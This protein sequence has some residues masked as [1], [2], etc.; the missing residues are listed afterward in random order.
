MWWEVILILWFLLR[1]WPLYYCVRYI[2]KTWIRKGMNSDLSISKVGCFSER[3]TTKKVPMIND[4]ESG[5]AFL[6][7]KFTRSSQEISIVSPTNV[8]WE[9]LTKNKDCNNDLYY[10]CKN[11]SQGRNRKSSTHCCGI[12]KIGLTKYPS[13]S[14]S[15]HSLYGEEEKAHIERA[16]SLDCR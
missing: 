2:K 15:S 3:A 7:I 12:R 6:Q 13:T 14:F 8:K 9:H 11:H 5:A 16:D 1:R 10:A 4:E